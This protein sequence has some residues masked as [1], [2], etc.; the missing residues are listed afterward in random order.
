MTKP[1][2]F[3]VGILNTVWKFDN[4]SIIHILREINFGNFRSTKSAMSTHLEVLNFDFYEFLHFVKDKI[5]QMAD[6]DLLKSAKVDFT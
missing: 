5:V 6:F 4:F 1:F 3:K 2:N